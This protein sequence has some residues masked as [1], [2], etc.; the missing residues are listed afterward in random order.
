MNLCER[1]FRFPMRALLA[2]LA[3]LLTGVAAARPLPGFTVGDP[4]SFDVMLEPDVTFVTAQR[5]SVSLNQAVAIAQRRHPGR[6]VRAETTTRNGRTVHEIRI[7]G[8]DGSVVT[9]RID[10][11]SGEVR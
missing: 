9:V 3:L 10:A 1:K 8:D 5:G 2:S 7:L 6:V 4:I 11:A